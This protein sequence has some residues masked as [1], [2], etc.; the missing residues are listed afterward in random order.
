MIRGQVD[1]FDQAVIPLSIRRADGT[2][3]DAEAVIDTGFSD[4]LTLPLHQIVALGLPFRLRQTFTLAD[5][6]DVEFDT[7]RATVVWDHRDR[8]VAVLAA[9]GD[10]LVGMRMLRGHHVFLDVIDGGAVRIEAR[11]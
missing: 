8:V 4:Y 5:G 11:P 10:I 2:V 9:E 3:F 7:Y 1:A 6:S